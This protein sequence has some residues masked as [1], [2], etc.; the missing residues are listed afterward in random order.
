[1][2]D[3]RLGLAP[4]CGS[5][6][7]RT[8]PPVDAL[9][10][11]R[12]RARSAWACPRSLPEF[13]EREACQK[14][15]EVTRMERLTSVDAAELP[16]DHRSR[17]QGGAHCPGY[18]SVSPRPV[19]ASPVPSGAGLGRDPRHRALAALR[20]GGTAVAARGH[21]ILLPSLF[22]LAVALVFLA[23]LVLLGVQAAREAHDAM[24]WVKSVEQSGI[25]TPNSCPIFHTA[26]PRPARGG[27]KISATRPPAPRS[28]TSSTT[29]PPS[30]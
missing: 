20:E 27:A 10:Y 8:I 11:M 15:A 14:A 24:A 7:C 2:A 6:P 25:P 21:N 12:M 23:P 13:I 18:G 30:A 5:G 9:T 19:G 16:A 29:R 4:S 3:T 22:T 26:Q 17:A 1:M 28:C